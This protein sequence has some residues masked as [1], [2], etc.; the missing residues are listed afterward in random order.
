[1]SVGRYFFGGFYLGRFVLGH[2]YLGQVVCNSLFTPLLVHKMHP[3]AKKGLYTR[4][5]FF[6]PFIPEFLKW[7][8]PSLSLGMSIGANRCF[9]LKPHIQTKKTTTKN[10]TA[11][12]VDPDEMGLNRYIFWS[13]GLKGVI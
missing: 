3:R 9:C 5:F 2:L 12:R 13:A 11:N 8:L 10:L 6:D 4:S 1:M 7:T